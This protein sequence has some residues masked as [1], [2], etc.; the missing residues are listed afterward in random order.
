[1]TA[2]EPESQSPQNPNTPDDEMDE[3]QYEYPPGLMPSSN[4]TYDSA[5][6][7]DNLRVYETGNPHDA[8]IESDQYVYPME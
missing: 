5:T 4:R 8:W 2:D 1:M 6:H 3:S 7:R